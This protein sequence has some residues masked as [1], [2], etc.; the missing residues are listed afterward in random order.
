MSRYLTFEGWHVGLLVEVWVFRCRAAGW[1]LKL[2]LGLGLDL[3]SRAE[4]TVE[5]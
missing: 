1:G 2:G 5:V 3:K 4:V